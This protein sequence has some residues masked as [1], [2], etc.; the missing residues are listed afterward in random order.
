MMGNNLNKYIFTILAVIFF[1]LLVF[2]LTIRFTNRNQIPPNFP[3]QNPSTINSLIVERTSPE[4]N[5]KDVYPGEIKILVYLNHEVFSSKDISIKISPDPKAGFTYVNSF[6]T[7]NLVI[8]V[9]GG[10][11]PSKEHTV[12]ISETGGKIIHTWNF[13]TSNNTPESSSAEVNKIQQQT[14]ES[15]YPL[16]SE[17]P[18]TT[19]KYTIDYIDRLTLEVT[20]RGTKTPEIEQEIEDW[21]LQNNVAPSSHT[22]IYKPAN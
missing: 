10:L 3:S 12:T 20:L 13:T 7:K 18:Y 19:D 21:M 16:F 15:Y 9:L 4:N 22:L 1:G 8:Q 14:I 11:T 6:P 2:I 17:V 5:E